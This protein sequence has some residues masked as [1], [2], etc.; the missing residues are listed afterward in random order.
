MLLHDCTTAPNCRRV[1]IFAAEKGIELPSRQVNLKTG[2]HLGEAFLALN[3]DATVPVLELDDGT[4]LCE[5]VAICQYL[6]ELY[7][8]P[9][10]LG[11]DAAHRARVSM[12]Q[13]RMEQAGLQAVAEAFR[14]EAPGLRDHALPGPRPVAQIPALAERGR[15]RYGWFLED[16]ERRLAGVAFV[17]GERFT[18]ADITA[19]VAVDFA[20]RALGT[21]PPAEGAGLARWYREVGARPSAAA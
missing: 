21:E 9:R 11:V 7:P 20:R 18:I 2:E 3:P 15:L 5:S 6:E 17:A 1:R 14:N 13:R 4:A 19:L 16:L 10:L 12:W 8:Q